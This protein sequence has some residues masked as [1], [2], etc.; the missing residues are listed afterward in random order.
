MRNERLEMND[1]L[2]ELTPEVRRKLEKTDIY[3]RFELERARLEKLSAQAWKRT[4]QL[5]DPAL[6]AQNNLVEELVLQVWEDARTI[7]FMQSEPS[8]EEF[9]EICAITSEP[10]GN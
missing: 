4:G 6:A 8:Y 2:F 5:S 9:Q 7:E 3:R 1:G 10:Y